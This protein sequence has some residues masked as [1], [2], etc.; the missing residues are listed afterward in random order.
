MLPLNGKVILIQT[1]KCRFSFTQIESSEHS[2]T[3]KPIK[4]RKNKIFRSKTCP[5]LH[6]FK[7][8]MVGSLSY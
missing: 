4:E 3:L 1:K 5:Y 6:S 8:E 7:L 2:G